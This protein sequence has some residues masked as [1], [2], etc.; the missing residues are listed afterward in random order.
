MTVPCT[1]PA[2]S[3]QA[4]SSRVI[5]R[6]FSVGDEQR[7]RGI[8]AR[9]L[10]IPEETVVA[11]LAKLEED[12]RPAHTDIDDIF[13][14]H[15]AAVKQHITHQ[16]AVS[17][18]RQ[19]F[20]GACFTMEYAIE[21]AAFFNPSMVQ[22]VDQ[23]NVPPGSVRFLMSL[24]ATGEGHISSIVFRRGLIDADGNVSVD[25]PGQRSRPARPATPNQFDKRTSCGNC[26]RSTPGRRTRNIPWTGLVTS[27]RAPSYPQ[28]STT[29]A[30]RRQ[31]REIGTIQ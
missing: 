10:T 3:A 20:I 30:N 21:S 18:A 28:P 12:F 23:S 25:S 31:S 2:D 7:V 16:D 9:A 27:L 13:R 14:E 24:R 29:S 15:Y 4:G 11:L 22:A 17:D 8:L 5:T 6:F 19:R 1:A 26:R